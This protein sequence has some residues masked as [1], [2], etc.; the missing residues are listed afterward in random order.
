M[1]QMVSKSK[2]KPQALEY[3]RQVE[4][5]GESLI[6]TDRGKPVLKI[7]PYSKHPLKGLMALR[8]SVVKYEKPFDPVGLE[9]WEH[10]K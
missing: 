8:D 7:L 2:F 10:L 1:E 9:D 3:F 4:E 5:S 6:I